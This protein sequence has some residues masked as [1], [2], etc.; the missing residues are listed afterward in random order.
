MNRTRSHVFS[1][2]EL[3][4][5]LAPRC[6]PVC[7][8]AV[9]RA[10]TET[11]TNRGVPS[12]TSLSLAPFPAPG[13][14][15]FFPGTWNVWRTSEQQK[16]GNINKTKTSRTR[17]QNN[18]SLILTSLTSVL[19]WLS[20]GRPLR[21]GDLPLLPSSARAAGGSCTFSFNATGDLLN[22]RTK[23]VLMSL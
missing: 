6:V 11:Q 15:C 8:S 21:S 14:S 5:C 13:P 16:D 4:L 17:L 20:L 3:S 9:W 18:A 19:S 1:A 22:N 2:Q 10:E 23:G 12:E 7:L